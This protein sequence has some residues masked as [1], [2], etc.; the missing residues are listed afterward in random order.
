LRSRKKFEDKQMPIDDNLNAG[1]ESD[2]LPHP[3]ETKEQML[4]FME[5]AVK[6]LSEKQRICVELFYLKELSYEDVADKTGFSMN[7]V[8]SFIQNGKRNL[9]IAISKKMNQTAAIFMIMFIDNV[10]N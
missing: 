9:K 3:E 2:L 4:Q 6:T 1:M 7:E 5:E 8:K 10:L